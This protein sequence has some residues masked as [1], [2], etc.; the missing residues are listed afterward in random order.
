MCPLTLVPLQ[1]C[2]LS[3][4]KTTGYNFYYCDPQCGVY[5]NFPYMTKWPLHGSLT[6]IVAD[7]RV[8]ACKW[9]I[10]FIQTNNVT[11][12]GSMAASGVSVTVLA[13]NGRRQTVKVSPNTPLL[14]VSGVKLQIAGFL[15]VSLSLMLFLCCP[16]Q[17]EWF[18]ELPSQANIS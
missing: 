17:G 9:S 8:S 10:K 4:R 1:C 5:F 16:N 7:S 12:L 13:P 18:S 15:G 6:A 3:I 11:S 14:Q 2:E